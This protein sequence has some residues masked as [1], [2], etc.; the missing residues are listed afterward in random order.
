MSYFVDTLKK[1][2]NIKANSSKLVP[3]QTFRTEMNFI[4]AGMSGIFITT[5]FFMEFSSKIINCRSVTVLT[6]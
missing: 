1:D 3:F 4:N 2:A 6:L 5:E